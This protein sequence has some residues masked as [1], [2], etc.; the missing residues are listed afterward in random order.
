MWRLKEGRYVG[1][2]TQS[3][4]DIQV[5]GTS[6]GHRWR[7]NDKVQGCTNFKKYRSNLKIHQN[8]PQ[9]HQKDEMKQVRC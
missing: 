1:N 9:M 2:V 6:C 5:T 7:D 8:S 4:V 3:C